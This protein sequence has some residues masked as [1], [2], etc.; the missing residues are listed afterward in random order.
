R[1]YGLGMLED[2]RARGLDLYGA[3]ATARTYAQLFGLARTALQ[4]AYPVILD[5]AF[6]RRIERDQAHA[7]AQDLGVP[8]FIVHCEAP[9]PVLRER[10]LA[11]RGD[12][13]EANV[14]VLEHVREGV[15]PLSGEELSFVRP[16]APDK[17]A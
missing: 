2:S 4:A 6:P 13:S 7:L 8:F 5:A 1:L 10:L 15:E 17:P 11:R 9:L 14:T 16:M 12:A 3:D